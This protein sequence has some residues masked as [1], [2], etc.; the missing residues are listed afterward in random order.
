ML[1]G[2]ISDDDKDTKSS[3]EVLHS[4]R[5]ACSSGACRRS[6]IV[7]LECLS[8][9]D[10]A[11]LGQH[12]DTKSLLRAE[13]FVLVDEVVVGESNADVVL[14]LLPVDSSVLQPLEV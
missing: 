6:S 14:V 3:T 4:L 5:L 13:E 2:A 1:A 11:P 10:V 8:Q 9:G 12:R 7:H